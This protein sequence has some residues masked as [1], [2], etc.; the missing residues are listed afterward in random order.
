MQSLFFMCICAIYLRKMMC[1]LLR[2]KRGW[3]SNKHFVFFFFT[4]VT[5]YFL[6]FELYLNSKFI[7]KVCAKRFELDE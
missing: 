5:I 2:M 1:I 7:F 3:E 4:K 6:M